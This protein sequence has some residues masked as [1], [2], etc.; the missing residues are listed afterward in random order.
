MIFH[1]NP[2][3]FVLQAICPTNDFF[4]DLMRSLFQMMTIVQYHTSFTIRSTEYCTGYLDFR[5]TSRLEKIRDG[6]LS[7]TFVQQL[8]RVRCGERCQSHDKRTDPC[9]YRDSTVDF[10]V[11]FCVLFNVFL[12][13]SS[14]S[15]SGANS[16]A[17]NKPRCRLDIWK[18]KIRCMHAVIFL[19]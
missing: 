1:S 18:R 19:R 4:T 17:Q 10:P 8:P 2:K 6:F 11:T 14:C 15:T 9:G 16:P 3:F 12:S 13:M 5:P 7:T